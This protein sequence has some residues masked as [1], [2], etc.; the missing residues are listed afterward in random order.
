MPQD[1]RNATDVCGN[2][3]PWNPPLLAWQ[4]GGTGAGNIPATASAAVAWPPPAISSGGAIAV[5]PSYTPTGPLT[6][7]PVPTFTS[8]PTSSATI[9]AGNGWANSADTAGMMVQIPSCSY[10]D[11]W[12]G[13]TVAPPSPLCSGAP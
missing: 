2:S 10:L 1:P 7:L 11:P 6:T 8:S 13:P 5:L 3:D 9:Y 4:T 12:V